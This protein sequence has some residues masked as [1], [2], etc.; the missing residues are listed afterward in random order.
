MPPT[1]TVYHALQEILLLET[2]T[3]EFYISIGT[4]QIFTKAQ[5]FTRER[6]IILTLK[7]VPKVSPPQFLNALWFSCSGQEEEKIFCGKSN[8]FQIINIFEV[9]VINQEIE[10]HEWDLSLFN[11]FEKIIENDIVQLHEMKISVLT[12]FDW[13]FLCIV[14]GKPYKESKIG[15]LRKVDDEEDPYHTDEDN[16][17][18]NAEI[19]DYTGYEDYT[20]KLYLYEPPNYCISMRHIKQMQLQICLMIRTEIG[21]SEW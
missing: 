17:K 14:V 16:A 21:I 20:D 5:E 3:A 4:T 15:R 1:V 9:Q 19:I 11:K 10:D 6:G 2:F 18:S 13:W 8:K 12:K 7:S